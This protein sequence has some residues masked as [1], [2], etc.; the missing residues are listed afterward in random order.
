MLDGLT[1]DPHTVLGVT[2][3][4]S[5]EEVRDAYHRK[6]KRYHP[7]VGG[8]EWAFRIVVR[9]YEILSEPVSADVLPP[10][11]RVS[12]ADPPDTGRIRLGMVD[13]GVEPVRR[14][15][16]EMIWMRYE[17]ADFLEL[18]SE[19]SEDRNLSGTL[20]I[21]WPDPDLAELAARLPQ[22][23]RIL[24]ALNAAFDDLRA[25][26]RPLTARSEIEQGR[27]EAMLG[28]SDGPTAGEAFKLF[29]VS[30]KARGLGVRQWT[31]DVTV[32]REPVG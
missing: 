6:S 8:D 7:D 30:L 10:T 25:R 13:K 2:R 27:F 1:L 31:R 17:V 32:P 5:A 26:T 28:Y 4:A 18:L 29:H 19:P 3:G 16:V 20:H 15:Q 21:V 23:D 24:R 12:V 11:S 22:A 14:V 9:A